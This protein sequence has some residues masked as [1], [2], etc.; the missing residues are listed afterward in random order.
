MKRKNKATIAPIPEVRT[1]VAGISI[2]DIVTLSGDPRYWRVTAIVGASDVNITSLDGRQVKHPGGF[3]DL[4]R[5]ASLR[6]VESFRCHV[7]PRPLK[8]Q[9][10]EF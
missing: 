5:K 4:Y 7:V 1:K 6:T 10:K 8:E 9:L 3:R 2:G